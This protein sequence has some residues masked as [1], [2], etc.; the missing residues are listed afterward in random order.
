MAEI[1]I[2]V[3]LGL[4]IPPRLRIATVLL[5]ASRAA[6]N[7]AYILS[8]GQAFQEARKLEELERDL[9]SLERGSEVGRLRAELAGA[10]E[11]KIRAHAE[12][13]R[14]RGVLQ[15]IEGGDA[16]C[17]DEAKLRQWAYEALTLGRSVDELSPEGGAK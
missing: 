17:T 15:R 1:D 6:G 12:A 8:P 2:P 13:D 5:A 16:P 10:R 11:A 9:A 3:T 7:G 14:L 4:D